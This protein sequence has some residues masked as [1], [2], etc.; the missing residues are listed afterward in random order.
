MDY[1]LNS[2]VTIYFDITN[3]VTDKPVYIS[4][5]VI[6]IPLLSDSFYK[7]GLYIVFDLYSI[8]IDMDI[9]EIFDISKDEVLK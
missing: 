5:N 9:M 2:N 1:D 3:S 6:S 8:N 4:D 7:D